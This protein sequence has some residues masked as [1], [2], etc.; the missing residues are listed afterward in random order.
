MIRIALIVFGFV[1]I[2]LTLI[3]MQPSAPGLKAGAPQ[4]DLAD[5]QEVSRAETGYDPVMP[6]QDSLAE[7]SMGTDPDPVAQS[8]SAL[9]AAP[10]VTP[11]PSATERPRPGLTD[12]DTSPQTLEK[13]IITALREGQNENYIDALVNDAATKGDV[14]VPGTLMT[15]DGRVDTATLLTV[16]SKSPDAMRAGAKLYTVQPGDSLAAIAFRFYGTT[17]NV[18][19]L[20]N[21]NAEVLANNGLVVGQELVIP[22]N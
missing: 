5:P 18:D 3:L 19:A 22:L 9:R 1:A 4:S 21:A 2:T 8:L 15:A 11:R 6:A 12:A 20:T 16:L 14:E 7:A 10:A 17:E 13:L